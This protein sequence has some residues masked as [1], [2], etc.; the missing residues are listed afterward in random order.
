PV[1]ALNIPSGYA[2]ANVDQIVENGNPTAGQ[3]SI[4]TFAGNTTPSTF[5]G[6]VR[7]SPNGTG[8]TLAL[9]VTQG[10]LNLPGSNTYTGPTTVTGGSLFVNNNPATGS[11][12]GFG[13]VTVS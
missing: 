12:T 6:T 2:G 11:G 1:A 5:P 3:N 10:S 8:G 7:N 4:L 9:A 13:T